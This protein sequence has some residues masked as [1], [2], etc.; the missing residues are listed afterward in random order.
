MNVL[1]LPALPEQDASSRF[2]MY[3]YVPHLQRN[4]LEIAIAPPVGSWLFSFFYSS[5]VYHKTSGLKYLL[6]KMGKTILYF[7]ILINRLYQIIF[8]AKKF[9][10]VVVH[11]T[12]F[13]PRIGFMEKLLLRFNQRFIYDFDDA[14]FALRAFRKTLPNVLAQ[15]CVVLAGNN[16]LAD[17]VRQFN[18]QVIVLPTCVDME[19]YTARPRKPDTNLIIG[20]TG[21]PWNLRHLQ[22]IQDALVEVLSRYN[23][24]SLKIVC[25]G[26]RIDFPPHLKNQIVYQNWHQDRE[27]ADLHTF[28]LGIMPLLQDEYARGKCGFK[29]IQYM[30]VG[31][32]VVCTPL[33]VN[34][35]IVENEVNGLH[36]TSNEE[37]ILQLCRLIENEKLRTELGMEGRQHIQE[38]Y[39]IKGNSPLFL[40]A[41]Q[42]CA[43]S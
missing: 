28:D 30:A 8:Q 15:A 11:R 4:G 27:V 5:I 35:E 32:P 29:L 7:L 22:G 17:Y 25:D 42:S 38:H 40:K 43:N 24:L 41:I 2:R 37:W 9:D 13:P 39:T 12:L 23:H 33:G 36:A 3:K 21:N 1:M 14:L 20:W 31:L 26:T 6:K 10:V 34:N 18:Q 19:R 16:F